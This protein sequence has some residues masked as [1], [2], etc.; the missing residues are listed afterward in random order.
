MPI[1]RT[2]SGLPIGVQIIGG[3]LEDKTTIAFAG[4]DRTR[5]RR[6]HPATYAAVAGNDRKGVVELSRYIDLAGW[7]ANGAEQKLCSSAAAYGFAP[8]RTLASE[9]WNCARP[10]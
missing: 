6:L 9:D 7:S 1:G 2:E 4:A 10:M 8:E 3:Y 5:V